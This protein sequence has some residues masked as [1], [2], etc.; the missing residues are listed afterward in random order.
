MISIYIN[1]RTF[2][3]TKLE[4]GDIEVLDED[5]KTVYSSEVVERV[6]QEVEYGDY[7]DCE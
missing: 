2:Y 1:D 5:G 4:D 6:L 7:E 3:Y